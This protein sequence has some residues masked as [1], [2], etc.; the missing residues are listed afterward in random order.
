V[1]GHQVGGEA[2]RGPGASFPARFRV[3]VTGDRRWADQHQIQV[4]LDNLLESHPEGL[5]IIE[6]CANGADRL[7]EVW[8]K[9][10]GQAGD[11]VDLWHYPAQWEALGRAA[12]PS[13]NVRMLRE[14]QPD[15]VHAFHDDLGSSRGTAHMVRIAMA[16]GVHVRLHSHLRKVMP[17]QSGDGLHMLRRAQAAQGLGPDPIVTDEEADSRFTDPYL[18]GPRA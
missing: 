11:P 8:A 15:E 1:S 9:Q 4:V 18:G 3:L 2:A 7:A 13:R 12:G 5:V 10:M 14:G 6:G 17:D 16:A